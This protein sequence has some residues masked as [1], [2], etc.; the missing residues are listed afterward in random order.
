VGRSAD[1]RTGGVRLARPDADTRYP[2]LDAIQGRAR[3][4]ELGLTQVD[5]AGSVGVSQQT[6]IT[7]ETGTLR[8]LGP[9]GVY[10]AL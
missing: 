8:A 4:K 6:L 10:L 9:P 1:G 3:R 7:L 2:A 5:P